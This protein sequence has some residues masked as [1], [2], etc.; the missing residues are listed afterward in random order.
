MKASNHDK[1]TACRRTHV[2]A[3][4]RYVDRAG[5]LDELGKAS[6]LEFTFEFAA[7]QRLRRGRTRLRPFI[8]QATVQSSI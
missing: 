5:A 7:G 8:D 6:H 3:N 4:E 1:A 2:G